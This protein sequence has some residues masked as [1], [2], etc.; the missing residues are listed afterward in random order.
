[1]KP[2]PN[3]PARPDDDDDDQEDVDDDGGEDGLAI[4]ANNT[5]GKTPKKPSIKLILNA[6]QTSA[7]K[8]VEPSVSLAGKISKAKGTQLSADK[9]QSNEN[10]PAKDTTESTSKDA[11]PA[12]TGRIQEQVLDSQNEGSASQESEHPAETSTESR[13]GF[14]NKT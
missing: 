2:K 11:G 4:N 12:D 10:V 5:V 7:T 6:P 14:K 3:K 9:G 1:M 13:T 8:K